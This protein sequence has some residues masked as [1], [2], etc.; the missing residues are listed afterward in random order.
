MSRV[1]R[2]LERLEKAAGDVG[3]EVRYESISRPAYAGG[4]CRVK[5]RWVV[6]V[7]RGAPPDEKVETIASAIATR[8]TD[9]VYLAP[10]VR[11]L[12]DR[13]KG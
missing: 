11:E 7:N 12:V 13:F 9:D 3:L 1:E 8:E 6:I 2:L 4:L 10:D 5:D